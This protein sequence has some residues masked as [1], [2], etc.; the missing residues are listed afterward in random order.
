MTT[1]ESTL[2]RLLDGDSDNGSDDVVE[3]LVE[4]APDKVEREESEEDE[5]VAIITRLRLEEHK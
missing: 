1:F 2:D 3:R 5:G 4:A